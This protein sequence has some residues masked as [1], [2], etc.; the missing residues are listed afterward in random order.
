MASLA[1]I[2]TH[3][4]FADLFYDGYLQQH[5]YKHTAPTAHTTA[6][7][8]TQTH[9]THRTQAQ[10]TDTTHSIGTS[11]DASCHVMPCH[12]ME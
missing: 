4:V 1:T 2:W 3:P 6:T 8:T 7:G 10:H 12:V 9:R 11:A 5:P